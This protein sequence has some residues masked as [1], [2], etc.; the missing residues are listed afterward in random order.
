MRRFSG[1]VLTGD[2]GSDE[3]DP[4]S[5]FF[6]GDGS[7]SH[8]FGSHLFGFGDGVLNIGLNTF[9]F[10]RLFDPCDL[11]A[12]DFCLAERGSS[13]LRR[14]SMIKINFCSNKIK[15][16]NQAGS[17]ALCEMLLVTAM[18]RDGNK[19]RNLFEICQ[20]ISRLP[21]VTVNS[22][23]QNFSLVLVDSMNIVGC[24]H[25]PHKQCRRRSGK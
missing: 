8:L 14:L 2:G 3:V 10:W 5:K 19:M 6:D 12:V 22:M 1:G 16:Y 25:E 23:M 24:R 18:N 17:R 11:C 15:K 21:A 4:Y 20:K 7:L 13:M 9:L